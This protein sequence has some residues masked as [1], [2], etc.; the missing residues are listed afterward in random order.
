MPGKL[1]V[2]TS[3]WDYSHWREVFYPAGMAP[4]DYLAFYA[5]HFNTV[6]L[7]NSFYRL[8]TR[9]GFLAWGGKVPNDFVF[10]VKASRYITH[11]KKLK[12]PQPSVERLMLNAQGLGQKLGPVLFQLPPKW[13]ANLE[14][15]REFVR[16]LPPSHRYAFEFRDPSWLTDE[17]FE[18]LR[19]CGCAL[20]VASSPS[21]PE[22]RRVTADF[23]FLRFHGGKEL[24]GSDYSRHELRDYARWA[25]PE[26]EAGK[27][28]YAY[29]NN[30]ARGYAIS[31][32]LEFRELL[33]GQPA[34]FG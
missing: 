31:N 11:R 20:C 29:F 33:A 27:D 28:L 16:V 32:A 12:D 19:V 18:L 34:A 9:E 1:Y 25:R 22:E 14:R 30:D 23:L 15:L 5:A 21:F 17:V 2:G 24:Y 8:P 4:E 26:L 6:E 10:A 3:G 13:H 7:N